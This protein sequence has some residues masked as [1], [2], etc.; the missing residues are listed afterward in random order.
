MKG[1][2][3]RIEKKKIDTTRVATFRQSKGSECI[4]HYSETKKQVILHLRKGIDEN[5]SNYQH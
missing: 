3:A 1:K 4:S 5:I 2:R